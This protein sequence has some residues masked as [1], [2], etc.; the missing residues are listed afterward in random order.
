MRLALAQAR[1]A[2]GRTFP[3]PPVGAVVFR[4]DRVLGR[5][6][7]RPPGGPHAEVVALE[8][9][10]H[11]YGAPALKGAAL[12][13]TLEP[14]RHWGRTGPC[15]D[16]IVA[17]RLGRVY[18][19]HLDPNPRMAGAGV[20]RL[21]RAGIEVS[22]GVLEDACR[23]QHRGFA[24]VHRRGRPFVTVKLAA[25]LDGRIATARG[26]SRWIT[27]PRARAF[28]HALRARTDAILI[29]AGTALADDP[30]LT[31]RDGRRVVH[32]P[33]RVLLDTRLRVPTRARLY[34][35]ADPER[36]WVVCGSSASARHRRAV[37]DT[38]A[39]VLPVATRA[40]RVALPAAL[41]RL[42]REGLTTLLAEGGGELA[43]AL[44]RVRLVDELHWLMAPRLLGGDARPAV[45]PLGLVRLRE[46]PGLVAPRWRRLGE[47]WHVQAGVALPVSRRRP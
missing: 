38:G 34:R 29:G 19:G 39:R 10:S 44:L 24:S 41:A 21:R 40:G 35:R 3:N 32:R 14:C 22:V 45:G 20:R 28:V 46:S 1:R 4:G 36:T 7:T 31:A 15:T 18:V 23:H 27:G 9:A 42:A 37:A 33:V 6:R 17:A 25:S 30:D 26:E 16:A 8:R 5:G 47:D 11:R 13:V 43:A 2:L 12:A